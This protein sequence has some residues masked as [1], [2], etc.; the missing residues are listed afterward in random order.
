M[1]AEVMAL[2]RPRIQKSALAALTSAAFL[3]ALFCTSLA[4]PAVW[5]F[6]I[7][8]GIL[9]SATVAVWFWMAER[10]SSPK[11]FPLGLWI[12]IAVVIVVAMLCFVLP[13]IG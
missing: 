13:A 6:A 10:R 12:V 2:T 3:G 5:F 1:R 4:T 7:F 9:I 8:G 11:S